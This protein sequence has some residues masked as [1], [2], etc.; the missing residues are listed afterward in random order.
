MPSGTDQTSAQL[1]PSI[2]TDK[3]DYFPA[4]IALISGKD[5]K[6]N[7]TY[8]I[9]ISSET[10]NYLFEDSLTTNDQGA[11]TYSY[12]LEN[13]YRPN[14]KVEIKLGDE[15]ILV[16]N[17]YRRSLNDQGVACGNDGQSLFWV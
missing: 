1:N 15:I 3:N 9:I 14:Y 12:R 7:T 6:P 10:D 2:S 5:L 4:E 11:F 13:T 17:F 16:D 8:K